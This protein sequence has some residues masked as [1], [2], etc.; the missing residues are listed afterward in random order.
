MKRLGLTLAGLL[1]CGALAFVWV[2][3]EVGDF[4]FS[5]GERWDF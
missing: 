1:F 3:H 2:K 5:L 4:D